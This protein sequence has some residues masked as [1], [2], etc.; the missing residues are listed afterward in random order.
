ML[1]YIG[2]ILQIQIGRKTLQKTMD[3]IVSNRCKTDLNKYI[4]TNFANEYIN[5]INGDIF[6][7]IDY[8]KKKGILSELNE[9]QV[10]VNRIFN[11]ISN[12]L[13]EIIH[14]KNVQ[15]ITRLGDMHGY[16]K[17][18]ILIEYEENELIFKPIQSHFLTLINEIFLIFNQS[19]RFS[20][21]ILK[22]LSQNS[23][24]SE[25]EFINNEEIVDLDIFSYHYG[26]IIFILT[27]LRG[28][29]FHADNIFIVSSTPVIIDYE[30]LFYPKISEFKVYDVTATS[31]IS[32]KNNSHT[33]M[34]KHRLNGKLIIKGI[35]SAYE[36][37]I[38]NKI[39][40]LNLINTYNSKL[41]RVIFKPTSY[42]LS[43]LKN[44]THP[45][46]LTV[47][48][49]RKNY[50]EKSL[51]GEKIVSS[52]IIKHELEDLM[53]FNIPSFYFKDGSLFSAKGTLIEQET[54]FSSLDA[55]YSEMDQLNNF[56]Y[57][58]IKA[59]E[60]IWIRHQVIK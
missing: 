1:G 29:D 8:Y 23:K 20:F 44:S 6:K 58:T 40:I 56:K 34:N 18:T 5:Y 15:K 10:V 60:E 22:I 49:N 30:T 17:C 54:I 50:L 12:Y 43:L 19:K 48:E 36:L 55:I 33:L 16:N 28:T 24:G 35:H 51:V 41:A 47:P 59:V 26:A 57:K 52:T 7:A 31:L 39:K 38:E 32:T 42:Y 25:I 11:N 46:L 2:I 45:A 9:L 37:A 4:I 27:L 53:D 3:H 14:N 13:T 21:Y